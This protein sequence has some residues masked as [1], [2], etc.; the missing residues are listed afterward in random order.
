MVK[1]VIIKGLFFLFALCILVFIITS[2]AASTWPPST[3]NPVP[4]VIATWKFIHSDVPI[5]TWSNPAN[6]TYGTALSSIQLTTTASDPTTG[7]QVAG[8]FVYNPPPGIILDVGTH[9]LNTTFTPTDT[10]N[11]TTASKSASI[12]VTTVQDPALTLVKLASPTTYSKIGQAIKYTYNVRNPGQVAISTPI[13]VTDNNAGIVPIQNSGILN[14]GPSVTG[15]AT[16]KITT[17]ILMQV[18]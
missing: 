16:Y 4:I 18:L 15:T 7:N 1:K 6:I 17:L 12:N 13:T 3:A 2:A 14:P 9:T 8:T 5:I 11:Y 10:T